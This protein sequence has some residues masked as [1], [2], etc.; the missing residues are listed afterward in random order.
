M[1]NGTANTPEKNFRKMGDSELKKSL[2]QIL[3]QKLPGEQHLPKGKICDELSKK[4]KDLVGTHASVDV[5]TDEG[6]EYSRMGMCMVTNPFT[7]NTVSP[8]F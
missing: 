6:K 4:V 7:G 3:K 8:S 5:M 1:A 2:V